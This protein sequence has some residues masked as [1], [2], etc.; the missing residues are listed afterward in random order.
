MHVAVKV[1]NACDV[2]KIG[3]M[4]GYGYGYDYADASSAQNEGEL[5]RTCY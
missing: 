3:V 5:S 2:S 4:L 1:R